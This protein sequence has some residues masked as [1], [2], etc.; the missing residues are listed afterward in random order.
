MTMEVK[1]P[2]PKEPEQFSPADVA[3]L[4]REVNDAIQELVR[5][6]LDRETINWIIMNNYA[7]DDVT[8]QRAAMYI[9]TRLSD[10]YVDFS[11]LAIRVEVLR[12]ARVALGEVAKLKL[13]LEQHWQGKE[14]SLYN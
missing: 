14:P 2:K 12:S 6:G 9:D 10:K 5:G 7:V 3:T 1:Q 4:R 11:E 8:K 13:F